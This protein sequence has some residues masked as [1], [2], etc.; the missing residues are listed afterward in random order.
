[1][2]FFLVNQA[3][4]G[5]NRHTLLRTPLGGRSAI[6]VVQTAADLQDSL[7]VPFVT[8]LRLYA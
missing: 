2:K 3:P 4:I 6:H 8:T 7:D 1:M 5:F